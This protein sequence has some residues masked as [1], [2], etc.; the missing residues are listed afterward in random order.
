MNVVVKLI[1]GL[2]LI[3][4]GISWYL[5]GS[6]FIPIA[7]VSSLKA[8]S[9]LFTGSMGII[10]LLVGLLI[11]WT[12]TEELKDIARDREIEKKVKSKKK[13]RKKKK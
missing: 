9:I 8:L 3:I 7:G 10:L 5:Y 2:M 12:E 11:T 13:T 4:A 1:I 6:V